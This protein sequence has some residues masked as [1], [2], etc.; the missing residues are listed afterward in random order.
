MNQ[1]LLNLI[2][3]ADEGFGEIISDLIVIAR[4]LEQETERAGRDALSSAWN[5]AAGLLED[6]QSDL[7]E[8]FTHP[9]GD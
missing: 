3:K 8:V 2:L 4:H 7:P 1:E 6:L 9:E 5:T